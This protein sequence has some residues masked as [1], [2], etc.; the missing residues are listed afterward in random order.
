MRLYLYMIMV[1]SLLLSFSFAKEKVSGK[2]DK[3][4]EKNVGGSPVEP[5]KFTKAKNDAVKKE[6][7]FEDTQDFKDAQQGFIA[8]F[9]MDKVVTKTKLGEERVVW[10]FASYSFVTGDS[11]DSVNPSL[12]RNAV[13]NNYSGLFKVTEG[14][15]QIRGLDLANM[16]IVEAPEGLILIDVLTLQETAKAALDLYYKH[17]PK[18][19]VVAVIYTHSHADHFGGVKGVVSE[20]D[21]KSGKVK[22]YAP[23]GFLEHAVSENVYA[24]NA[25][26]RRS[27]YGYGGLLKKGVKGQVDGGLAKTLAT[28]SAISLI[29]PTHTIKENRTV[30]NIAGL[31]VDFYMAHGT[32]APSEMFMYFP[33]L[34]VI[35]GA[36]VVSHTMH[37]INTLRGAQVRDPVAWW[38]SINAMID[39]YADDA[40]ILM[41]SHH[42]PTFG[43]DNLIKY[44]K[45]QRDLYKSLHDQTLFYVNQGYT[46]HEL[47]DLIKLPK[48]ISNAWYN[49]GYYG[50]ISHNAKAIYQRYIGWY[51]GNPANLDPLK[52]TE[53]AK[54]YVSEMGGA[55]KV[56][57]SAKKYYDKGE[58]RWAATL[59]KHVVFADAKNTKAK[60]LLAKSFE[61]MGYVA[62]SATWRNIYLVGADELRNGLPKVPYI[63]GSVDVVTSMTPEMFFD[64]F[65]IT[66]D[67]AKVPD[68]NL[69]FNWIFT[70]IEKNFGISFNHGVLVYSNKLVRNPIATI[71]T[72]KAVLN[73][74][75]LGL[76]TIKAELEAGTIKIEGDVESI[77]KVKS[78]MAASTQ[79][80]PF[81]NIVTP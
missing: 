13:L 80:D 74:L 61:Q 34:K 17:R 63:N 53:E 81:F 60:E 45:N 11:P 4:A 75:N 28:G 10:D 8:K 39:E 12:W 16:T 38:K 44:L 66:L 5:S 52:P 51:D 37:N 71:Y 24:G 48:P 35:Q 18:K 9:D 67:P 22:I 77:K 58:Y 20:E 46:I 25:M 21:V 2:E 55:E 72:T 1:F 59:L 26:I 42:W 31:D 47:P 29:A 7:N 50:T 70:D 54:R 15:Y 69:E 62:E 57:S 14:V 76:T 40:E 78:V 3:V 64:Y 49:R 19:P 36:E 33:K 65:S 32:E 56:I 43:K 79:F 6:L 73:K 30:I 27:I 23:E 68:L 41:A